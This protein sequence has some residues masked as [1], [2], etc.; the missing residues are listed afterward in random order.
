MLPYILL[1]LLVGFSALFDKSKY[2]K[3]IFILLSLLMLVF[4]GFRVGGTGTGDYDAYLRLYSEVGSF[5]AVI[6]PTIHAEIGF[7]FLSFVG[8]SLG[9]T[10]QFIIFAMAFLSLTII[11]RLIYKLSPY[12]LLSLFILLPF[13]FIFN[14]QTSR[15]AVAAAFGVLF[16]HKFIDKEFLIAA[17]YLTLAVFFHYSALILILVCL[18]GLSFNMLFFSMALSFMAGLL[19]NPIAMLINIFNHIGFSRLSDFLSIYLNSSEYGYPMAIYDPRIM[20]VI[21]V[22]C[23]IYRARR[24]L[25][26]NE[27]YYKIYLIGV[28]VLLIFSSNTAIALRSSYYFLIVGV[29]VIPFLSEAYNIAT[30]LNHGMKRTLSCVFVVVYML[31]TFA[32]IANFQPYNFIV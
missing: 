11:L 32:L 18:V 31:Y 15:T 10:G 4:S 30:S 6:N 29:L 22:S 26:Y 14:M 20:L 12:P 27:K 7:R 17:F 8:N 23:L 2:Q 16:L 21:G 28:M 19:L 24:S 5:D 3:P 13:F 1:T 25:R 9:L